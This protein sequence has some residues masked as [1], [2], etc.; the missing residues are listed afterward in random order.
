MCT[1]LCINPFREYEGSLVRH[2]TFVFLDVTWLAKILK[3]LLNHKDDEELDGSLSLGDTGITL[4]DDDHVASW[5]RLRD[6]G[7]LEP[8]LARV[9]WP[10]GLSDYVLPT[11]DSLGLTHPLEGDPADGLVVL[12]R[13]GEERPKRVGKELDDFKSDHTAVFSVTWK[14]FMGVPPGAIEKVLT[15]CCRIG[16]LRTFWRFGVLVQGNF[17]AADAVK[18][19]ALLVEYSHDKTELD[20]KVYGN[21]GTAAPW[22]ALSL[23]LSAARMMCSEFPGLRWRAYL[24]CPQHEEQMQIS[25]TVRAQL[26]FSLKSARVQWSTVVATL[27]SAGR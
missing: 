27:V 14:V 22:A 18:T 8:S 12:L 13:L 20:M 9:L 21:I 6:N 4:E 23:G 17:G 25:N 7:V 5:K 19:F 10:D 15:R 1:L 16:V 3:P 11:L 2:E 26:P 24:A